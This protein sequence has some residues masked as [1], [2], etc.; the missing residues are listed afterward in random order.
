[1]STFKRLLSVVLAF[2]LLAGMMPPVSVRA[3]ETEPFSV[4]VTEETFAVETTISVP[5]TTVPTE[6]PTEQTTPPTVPATQAPAETEAVPETEAITETAVASEDPAAST[7]GLP[8]SGAC[9]ENLTWTL[10]EDGTLTIS[11]TGAME[12]YQYVNYIPWYDYKDQITSIILEDGV[13]SICANAFTNCRA[14]KSVT[15]PSTLET[16]GRSAFS[17]CWELTTVTLREGLTTIDEYAFSNCSELTLASLPDSILIIGDNAFSSCYRMTLS[18]LPANL[19]YLGTAAFRYCSEITVSQVPQGVSAIGDQTFHG[20]A[21]IPSMTIPEGVTAIGNNAFV[22]C[23]GLQEITIPA[24]VT[25][26]GENIFESCTSLT[27]IHVAEGNT[28]F[29]SQDGVLFNADM[30]TLIQ[31]PANREDAAYTIPSSV[32]ELA[33][34]SFRNSVNLTSIEIPG[35]VTKLPANL[36]LYC[37]D[38]ET[39]TLGEDIQEIGSYAFRYSGLTDINIPASVTTISNSAFADCNA[40]SDITVA[41]G[42][43]NYCSHDGALMNTGKTELLVFPK[44]KTSF[45]IPETVTTL[46]DNAFAYSLLTSIEIPGSITVLPAYAFV[47]CRNLANVTLGEGV[48]S[49]GSYAFDGC[50]ALTSIEIPASVT[51]I[52]NEAFDGCSG[53]KEIHFKGDAPDYIDA[54]AFGASWSSTKVTATVFY[55]ADNATWTEDVMRNY[56]GTLTWLVE[57]TTPPVATGQCGRDLYWSLSEDGVLTI[58]GTG[59]MKNYNN[60]SEVPWYSYR[61]DITQ[62]IIEEGA[63]NVGSRTFY[64]CENLAQVTFPSTLTKIGDYA[65]YQC[66]ALTQITL[67]DTLTSIGESAF[68]YC[69]GLETVT[70]GENVTHIGGNAFDGTPWYNAQLAGQ[71]FV[72]V[73]GTLMEYLGSDSNVVIPEGITAIGA[74]AFDDNETLVSVTLPEGLTAIGEMAFQSCA[75]LR[76][77]NFPSTLTTIGEYAFRNCSSLTAAE[78]PEG[79]KTVDNYAFTHCT[80]LTSIVLPD[81]LTKLGYSAFSGCTGLKSIHIGS[82]LRALESNVFEGCTGLTRVVIPYTITI[83]ESY[84]FNGCTKLSDLS[85]QAAASALGGVDDPWDDPWYE[86]DGDQTYYP[87][88]GT[89]LEIQWQAFGDCHGLTEVYLPSHLNNLASTAFQGCKNTTFFHVNSGT[90]VN[91]DHG[92]IYSND[93]GP[94]STLV[95]VPAQLSG[96]FVVPASV[97]SIYANFYGCSKLTSITFNTNVGGIRDSD[98]FHGCTSLTE[99]VA[100]PGNDG[101]YYNDASG[102]LLQENYGDVYLIALPANLTTYTVSADVTSI[103]TSGIGNAPLTALHVEQGNQNYYSTDGVLF[104]EHDHELIKYPSHKPGTSYVIPADTEYFTEGTFTNLQYLEE[105]W[106][107]GEQI[108]INSYS[109]DESGNRL[110]GYFPQ[111]LWDPNFIAESGYI[112]SDYLV[113]KPYTLLTVGDPSVASLEPGVPLAVRPTKDLSTLKSVQ[114]DGRTVAASNYTVSESGNLVIFKT[115]YLSTLSDASHTFRLQFA[116]GYEEVTTHDAASAAMAELERLLARAEENGYY[117][118]EWDKPLT[119]ARDLT[120]GDT[121]LELVEGGHLTV[122]AGVTLTVSENADLL[123]TEGGILDVE[124]GGVLNNNGDIQLSGAASRLSC[125]GTFLMNRGWLRVY[126]SPDGMPTVT[127]IDR[128]LIE[129]DAN[130]ADKALLLQALSMQEDGYLRIYIS[131][132]DQDV[133]LDEDITIGKNTNL[134]I[135]PNYS[136][137]TNTTLTLNGNTTL[138]GRLNINS[139]EEYGICG[140]VQNNGTFTL[141]ST[142]ELRNYGQFLG[143]QPVTKP[144]SQTELEQQLAAAAQTGNSVSL[145]TP[146]TLERNL[147]VGS[148]LYIREGGHLTVPSGVTLTID[149]YVSVY[150]GGK[151]DVA[152]G[153]KLINN[154]GLYISA[155][156]GTYIHVS[157][158]YT[159]NGYA[160]MSQSSESA[161]LADVTG[162]DPS[163][164]DVNIQNGTEESLL[165]AISLQDQG[166]ASIYF[167]TTSMVLNTPVTIGRNMTVWVQPSYNNQQTGMILN[168]D[169]TLEGRLVVDY[170]EWNDS[171]GILENNGTLTVTQT[172]ELVIRGIYRGNEP[173]YQG[174]DQTELEQL[175]AQSAQTGDSVRLTTPLTLERNLTIPEDTYLTLQN[176]GRIVVP[177]GIT[178]TID[179]GI[180]VGNGGKLDVEPGGKLINNGSLNNWDYYSDG[181]IHVNGDYVHGKYAWVYQEGDLSRMAD[182]TGID[183]EYISLSFYDDGLSGESLLRYA[184]T[185][186]DDGYR[187]ICVNIYS[188]VLNSDVTIGKNTV[189][190]VEPSYNDS[191]FGLINNGTLTLNGYLG[192]IAYSDDEAATLQ[193]NGKLIVN[194]TGV[195]WINGNFLGN[196]PINNGGYIEDESGSQQPEVPSAITQTKLE[197]LLAKNEFVELTETL[198]LERNLTIKESNLILADGGQLIV[199]SGKTLTVGNNA[200]LQVIN[201][202]VLEVNQG[203]K[204]VNNYWIYVD[205]GEIHNSGTYVH[206]KDSYGG[207]A[208]FNAE[209]YALEPS[210]ITGI[211]YAYLAVSYAAS[212]EEQFLQALQQDQGYGLIQIYAENL[213]LNRDVTIAENVEVNVLPDYMYMEEENVLTING[214][215]I[216]KGQL[217]TTYDSEEFLFGVI[218]NNGSLTIEKSGSFFAHGRYRGNAPLV[219]GGNIYTDIQSI[220]IVEETLTVDSSREAVAILTVHAETLNNNPQPTQGIFWSS[221]NKNIVNPEA[222]VSNGNGTYTVPFTGKALGTVKLTAMSY[223]DKA[224]TDTVTLTVS[225][226]DAA[227]KLTASADIPAIGLQP[228]E[229]SLMQ[230]FGSDP[231]TPLNVQY[232]TFTSSDEA[233]ASVDENGTITA[234]TKTGT[235]K[236]TAA[237]AGDP[238][239]RTVVLSVKVIAPQTKTLAILDETGNITTGLDL[240][241]ADLNGKAYTF[242]LAPLPGYAEG[243]TAPALSN[244]IIKWTTSDSKLATVKANTDGTATVTVK[245]GA[246]GVCTISAQTTDLANITA[247]FQLQ[248]MDRSPRLG[249]TSA[250][251]NPLLDTGAKLALMASYGNTILADNITLEDSRF[252]TRYDAEQ[253]ILTILAAEN[254]KNGTVNTTLTVPCQDGKS[255][256]YNLK[257]SVKAQSPSLTVKQLQK[258]DL[259]Y[260]G[261]EAILT[262]TAKDAV[263]TDVTL[264][265]TEDFTIF[266][267]GETPCVIFSDSYNLNPTG[268]PDTKATLRVFLEGYAQPVEKAITIGTTSTKLSLTTDPASSVLNTALT[269][270]YTTTFHIYDKKL[271]EIMPLGRNDVE[272][273]EGSF[274]EDWSVTEDG[275]LSLTVTGSGT[276]TITLKMPHWSQSVKLTH[277]VTT[278]DKLPTVKLAASTL[279]L[280]GTFPGQ[281]DSSAVTLSQSNLSVGSFGEDNTFV[282]TAKAGTSAYD[283]AAKIQVYYDGIDIVAKFAD[284]DNVPKNGTYTYTAVPMVE[285]TALKALT[286]KVNVSRQEPKVKLSA[287]TLKLNTLLTGN[288]TAIAAVTLDNKTGYDLSVVDF[289]GMDAHEEFVDLCFDATSG[290]FWAT[291]LSSA[292][293]KYTY[294]LTPVVRDDTGAEIALSTTVKLTVQA[295]Q[296]KI[297]ISQSASGKLDLMNPDSSIVYTVK[298]ISNANGVIGDVALLDAAGAE[299]DLFLTIFD[300]ETQTA[301][302]K[303][304]PE[305]T[306]STK[307]TYKV[308]L[309]YSLCGTTVET[310]TLSIKVTQSKLKVTAEQALFFQSQ[311]L[312]LLVKL[313]VDSPAGAKMATVSV[314]TEKTADALVKALDSENLTFTFPEGTAEAR[315]QLTVVNPGQLTAGKSYTLYLD[316]TPL[317]VS[318]PTEAKVT[319]SVN[320]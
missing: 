18:A 302:L 60:Y 216:L 259:F 22:G 217:Y 251:L 278:N 5:E 192:V 268:K 143:N 94:M 38:L 112:N 211:D 145:R 212:N 317:G 95:C 114:V 155:D 48:Q 186:E 110:T 269:Q 231:E 279:K 180:S 139:Y 50:T 242:T 170:D 59:A 196:A 121:N 135:S 162:I 232:L 37:Y 140:I 291:L 40:L 277:K 239:K 72:I 150:E 42:N 253:G 84:A 169:V 188:M 235:A 151:L 115:T 195:L 266:Y 313:S 100:G 280:S 179:G 220:N 142:A 168:A 80:G 303:L 240:D 52:A 88:P 175:L 305:K 228:G 167:R 31:Y 24:S 229:T 123:L 111:N 163:Y 66:K 311:T 165:Q 67:P 57:G 154:G 209:G 73:S 43:A 221:S 11:G 197:S 310:A 10:T 32:T 245:A 103:N 158:S 223:F 296:S 113:W 293:T 153:G 147:T 44:T 136:A 306:Y 250:T 206:G 270:D 99:I 74:N 116:S 56:G 35:S 243:V 247:D 17:S 3:E 312:P 55:P 36:F 12:E 236:I 28:Q 118:V 131:L 233:I 20:C 29:A 295:Q 101:G 25:S 108:W 152:P 178:L 290:E 227:K 183:K 171:C 133:T 258:M 64:R 39:V 244:K 78:L 45:S 173:V 174:P 208:W 93:Y 207:P 275:K 272:S 271:K 26:L 273:V 34:T 119:L 104:Y 126:L 294:T 13:T 190:Y 215:L 164:Q 127:G 102:A 70:M 23:S 75:N 172:G 15:A 6:E 297:S 210:H 198:V 71:E 241:L 160:Y 92:I 285:G 7:Q 47:Y 203:G 9:G 205:G 226:L 130:N 98:A 283:E 16:I 194:P 316:V 109:F 41:A 238:L 148:D 68:Y 182:I 85:F 159:Q 157:G 314:N 304:N 53:L 181:Y 225:Y 77:I 2:A 62:V 274:V 105:L 96:K 149:G 319:I 90:Y 61:L 256:T 141:A 30:T 257:L 14:L 106:F 202:G 184:L 87:D 193:N 264:A 204:L 320:R 138:E 97:E 58:T 281:T 46:S 81:S 287:S 263:V 299:T 65:F 260:L 21:K 308:K 176:T 191:Q 265:D 249:S 86:G 218:Q 4:A 89:A 189:L 125:D 199:P 255:Y 49:I 137:R 237:I 300:E 8:A 252:Q 161:A 318:E 224:M 262:V 166:Y 276:A 246:H 33:D 27:A 201:G 185:F 254:I 284:P 230:V 76:S 51:F 132:G 261:S 214:S 267:N 288:E 219:N 54:S 91:D 1:M 315:L 156:E 120:I 63:T 177:S 129:V 309:R 200:S 19:I 289:L 234:G 128:R 117:S 213:T 301:T 79:I 286:V 69:A 144:L 298:K 307:E 222:I 124:A 83:I 134:S 292:K 282:T 146:L 122:P 187:E 82:G 107:T 248:I